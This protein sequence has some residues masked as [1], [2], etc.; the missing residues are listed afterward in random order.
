MARKRFHAR[1]RYVKVAESIL[2]EAWPN[3]VLAAFVRLMAY[4]N[5]RWA[6][7][8]KTARDAGK[9]A[10]SSIDLQAITGKH[11]ADVALKSA[12]RLADFASMSVERRGD[13]TLIDWPKFAAFQGYGRHEAASEDDTEDD[14]SPKKEKVPA[15]A[16]SRSPS[17]AAIQFAEDYRRA[18]QRTGNMRRKLTDSAF[19]R[20]KVEADRMLRRDGIELE[21]ARELCAWIFRSEDE[22]A[23]FWRATARSVPNFRRNYDQINA[24]RE[25]A[26]GGR[27]ARGE[28]AR[29]A[30][31]IARRRGLD[32]GGD[33]GPVVDVR[34]DAGRLPAPE[35]PGGGDDA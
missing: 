16:R 9:A 29:A 11:R 35:E 18:L 33:G 8:Q 19:D 7:D 21:E 5:G 27:D 32:A 23:R 12:R 26:E 14:P 30:A 34:G 3:D 4:L 25:R 10:I 17:G 28:G 20:W 24:Q 6:S 2:W 31:R 15:K 1:T 13:V 22:E